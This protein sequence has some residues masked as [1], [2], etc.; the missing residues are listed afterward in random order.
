[1]EESRHHGV[2]IKFLRESGPTSSIKLVCFMAEVWGKEA[3]DSTPSKLITVNTGKK[4]QYLN[5]ELLL[6]FDSIRF[7]LYLKP[8]E[9]LKYL[10][11]W[12]V[13][14][15][16]MFKIIPNGEIGQLAKL[17][18]KTKKSENKKIHDFLLNMQKY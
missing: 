15:N 18:S 16:A 5:I 1:M 11:K 8:N 17:T 12:S 7:G 9:K 3:N 6:E 13:H 14:M 4:F 10:N 2:A